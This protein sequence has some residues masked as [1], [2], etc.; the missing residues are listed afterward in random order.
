[1]NRGP[2]I[3][4]GILL[5]MGTAWCGLI[6]APHLQLGA[7]Q[8]APSVGISSALYP[9]RLEGRSQQGAEVYRSLG[10]AHCHSQNVRGNVADLSRWGPRRTVSR[11]YLYDEPP[12]PGT[13]RIGPDLSNAGA[14]QPDAAWHLAHLYQPRSKVVKS[15]M[16]PY[17]FLFEVRKIGE[18]PSPKALRLESPYAPPE[19]FEVVPK[20]EA[21][22]LVAYL[23]DRK[24]SVALFEAPMPSSLK[25]EE[26][27]ATNA[28]TGAVAP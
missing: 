1:M 2:L 4:A 17:P 27:G 20:H 22:V 12:L 28:P 15:L 14:R 24:K 11:D 3:F 6:F 21:E 19:G 26:A 10:C 18:A 23:L 16:P 5:A 9:T 13:L 8:P 25:K 7:L